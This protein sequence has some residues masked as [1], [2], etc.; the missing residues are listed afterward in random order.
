MYTSFA[1]VIVQ[2][3]LH[4]YMYYFVYFYDIKILGNT[5]CKQ[6]L[7]KCTDTYHSINFMKYPNVD[8]SLFKVD[9]AQKVCSWVVSQYPCHSKENNSSGG[10]YFLGALIQMIIVLYRGFRFEMFQ[11][12]TRPTNHLNT[13]PEI[14][15][16]EYTC[17]FNS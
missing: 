15:I 6:R 16:F 14:D 8:L 11:Y 10:S 1:I 9:L 5:S 3:L 2:L 12:Y 13:K 4:M 7:Y 17:I